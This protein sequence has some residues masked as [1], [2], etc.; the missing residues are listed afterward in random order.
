M[1][2]MKKDWS[3]LDKFRQQAGQFSSSPGATYGAFQIKFNGVILTI[4]ATDGYDGTNDTG[5]E[6][7]SVL[8]VDSTFNKGRIPKW[9]E[10]CFVAS[11]F[12]DDDEVLLQLRPAKADYVNIHDHVLHWWKPKDQIISIPPKICV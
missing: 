1:R 7:V 5:W 11:L 10:M 4:I 12:W 6:H 2:S 9:D 8:V 3:H